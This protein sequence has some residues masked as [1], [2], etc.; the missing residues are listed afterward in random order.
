MPDRDWGTVGSKEEDMITKTEVIGILG[1]A[2]PSVT[3]RSSKPE[4]IVFTAIARAS[5][6]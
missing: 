1:A 6:L 3:I 4:C 5:C 2:P